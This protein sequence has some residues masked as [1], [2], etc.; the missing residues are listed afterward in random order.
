MPDSMSALKINASRGLEQV[1]IDCPQPNPTEILIKVEAI[2]LNPADWVSND[3]E[4]CP[5]DMLV[6]V[7]T[8]P[9]WDVSGTVV[10]LGNGVT[11]FKVGDR[12]F[13]MPRF[14]DFANSY[15]EYMTARSREVALIPDGVSSIDAGAIPL[16]GLTA[17]QALVDTAKVGEG[18]RVLVHAASGGVGHLAVQIAK[19][20]GAEVWGTASS[21][22]HE[23]LNKLGADHLIDYKTE[24]FEDVATD[25]DIVLLLGGGPET[26]VRSLS[27]MKKGGRLVCIAA[28]PPAPNLLEDAG[29]EAFFL[30]VEPDY[31][32]LESLAELMANGQLTV[33]IADQKP[34]EQIEDLHALGKQGSPLGKLVAIVAQ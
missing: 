7:G 6:P 14:P 15:A 23:L 34:F 12:V 8:I 16:A 2:G 10:G 5:P 26:G 27:T 30:L 22:N 11:R 33:V 9:G 21:H 28:P 18:D 31:K 17:W 4:L 1:Q 32:S 13:G 24:N 29:V 20:H 3:P 19:A 25:M